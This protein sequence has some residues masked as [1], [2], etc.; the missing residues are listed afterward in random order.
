MTLPTS[1]DGLSVHNNFF[2][3]F[4][5][6]VWFVIGKSSDCFHN[7]ADI[8]SGDAEC[9]LGGKNPLLEVFCR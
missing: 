1:S 5:R 6:G 3:E 7:V 2:H 4:I 9:F 8:C